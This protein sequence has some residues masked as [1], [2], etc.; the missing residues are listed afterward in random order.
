MALLLSH[1]RQ[2]AHALSKLV[3][4]VLATA[5]NFHQAHGGVTGRIAE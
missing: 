3:L 4:V 2:G 1:G 5:R